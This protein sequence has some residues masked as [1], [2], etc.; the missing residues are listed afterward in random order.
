MEQADSGLMVL[1]LPSGL[2]RSTTQRLDGT[3]SVS[4]DL[5]WPGL[6]ID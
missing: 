2:V 6:D 5:P 1:V 3:Q 4:D